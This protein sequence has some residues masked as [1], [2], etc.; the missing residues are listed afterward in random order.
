M[1]H[2]KRIWFSIAGLL[3][4][5]G[6]GILTVSAV[7]L[8]DPDSLATIKKDGVDIELRSEARMMADEMA[9][10]GGL[11]L[12]SEVT[13]VPVPKDMDDEIKF[14]GSNLQVND[15]AL[16][17]IQTF[18]LFRPFVDFTQSE[19]TVAAHGKNVVVSYNTSANQPLVQLAPG[20]LAFTQRFFSG[21]SASHDGGRTFASG[22]VPP[23]MGGHFTFGDG[24]VTVDRRGNFYYATLG[25]DGADN[26]GT[27]QVNKSTDGGTTFGPAVIVQTDD[28]SDKEWIG[29]GPD[30]VNGDRDNIYVTWTSFQP[31]PPVGPGGSQLRFGRSTDGGQTWTTKTLFAPPSDPNPANPQNAIQFSVPVV[32]RDTGRLFIGFLHFSNSDQDFIRLLI[33]DD[34]GETFHFAT[35]NILGAPDPTLL[36]ITTAGTLI[37]CGR[38]NGGFRPTIHQGSNIGGG[39]FGLPR[40]IRASRLITQPALAVHNGQVFLAWSNSTSPFF[41]DPAASSNILFKSSADGGNT[42]SPAIQVNPSVPADVQHVHPAIAISK[43][44]DAEA[45]L[46]HISYYTQHTDETVDLDQAN[47]KDSGNSFPPERTVRVTSASSNL[48]PTNIPLPTKANP[49]A[50][51]NYDRTVRACYN[52]GEYNGVFRKGGTVFAVWGDGRNMVTHPVNALDPLSGQTHPQ[53]DVLIQ[54]LKIED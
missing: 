37:D 44:D 43:P 12:E 25:L 5:A 49:F 2:E 11:I 9:S 18:P 35:F 53:Q 42:W 39:R 16:D 21:F 52:L 36:P 46:V 13:P 41:G 19:T 28:G 15:P 23:V 32:D 27:V 34:A 4:I 54:K 51:T 33:S 45:G 48:A 47:S 38:G 14:R 29:V 1:F 17:N 50:T 31:G 26:H 22:F 20:V 10:T 40:F 7:P 6:A 30:P 3:L 8:L 24:V